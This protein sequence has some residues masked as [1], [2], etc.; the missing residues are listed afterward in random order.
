MF[1]YGSLGIVVALLFWI[2][3]RDRPKIH[4]LCNNAEMSLIATGRPIESSKSTDDVG[5]VPIKAIL[6]SRS[7]WLMC[8][9]Q[10]GSNVGW[11]FLVTW[12]PRYLL[13]VHSAP[14]VQRGLMASIPLWCGWCGM[15]IGGR[16]SD[17]AVRQFGLGMG[18]LAPLTF[19]RFSACAAYVYCLTHPSAWS[20]TAAFAVVAFST[21]MGSASSW[22]YKQD[23]G[24]RHVASIHGW[25][26]MWDNL[27]ATVSP[28]LL[29]AVIQ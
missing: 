18:R 3:F 27:G 22:A 28:I 15:L 8:V 21:D 14:L 10:W 9:T 1:V 11:V 12:L 24:G 29:Q 25:A 16:L 6:R 26:N 20:I 4:P 19:G 23:V 5:P 2:S 17:A 7:L 13:E